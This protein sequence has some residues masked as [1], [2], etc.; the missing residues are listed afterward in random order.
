MRNRDD[1][2][3]SI[4][5]AAAANQLDARL[6]NSFRSPNQRPK[7]QEGNDLDGSS[8]VSYPTLLM[9]LTLDEVGSP[10]SPT[11]AGEG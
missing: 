7:E 3:P 8:G 2:A 1:I 11:K 10:G 6:R 5:A 4:A 9:P